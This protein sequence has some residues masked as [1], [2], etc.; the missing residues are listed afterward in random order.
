MVRQKRKISDGTVGYGRPPKATQFKKGKSG[1]PRGRPKGSRSIGLVLQEVLGQRI[2]VTENG[3]TRR[4]PA[5]EVM[6]RR[7]ANDAMR[8]EPVALKLML[9]LFDRYG[10]SPEA[11]I[12]LDEILEEDKAILANFL[13][14]PTKGAGRTQTRKSGAHRDV[15]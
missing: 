7:L 10:E 12:K 11:T 13:K 5:L 2:A 1:N 9:S 14:M 4:L 15:G 3:K 8:S 6:L